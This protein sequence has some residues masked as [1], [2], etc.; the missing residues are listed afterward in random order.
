MFVAQQDVVQPTL[1]SYEVKITGVLHDA[2]SDWMEIPADIRSKFDK[3]TRA[4]CV[5]NFIK[6]R[7]VSA[8]NGDSE[9][10]VLPKG[11]TVKFLF[12]GQKQI[13]DSKLNQYFVFKFPFFCRNTSIGISTN[14]VP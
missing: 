1:K 7:A 5:F 11:R 4:N 14:D 9:I 12:N 10:R 2:W 6:L 13:H 3:T 8:F